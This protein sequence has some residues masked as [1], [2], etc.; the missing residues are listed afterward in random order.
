MSIIDLDDLTI[1]QANPGEVRISWTASAATKANWLYVDGVPLADNYVEDTAARSVLAEWAA[2]ET[3]HIE[4]HEGTAGDPVGPTVEEVNDLPRVY[5]TNLAAAEEYRIYVDDVRVE[6]VPQDTEVLRF[7]IMCPRFLESGWNHLR[8]EAVDEY[9]QE[10]TRLNW[11]YFVFTPLPAPTDIA[12]S[13]TGPYTL[14]ITP[15]A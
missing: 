8:V 14:T 5:W 7:G 3:R 13:G 10:S 6:V 12:V 1:E 11:H 9:G 15:A 4:L 2:G